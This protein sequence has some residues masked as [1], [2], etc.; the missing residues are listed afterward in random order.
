MTDVDDTPAPSTRRGLTRRTTVLAGLVSAAVLIGST[1]MVW[2]EASGADLAG[3]EQ[4]IDVLGADAAPAAAAVAMVAI[5]AAVAT[6]LSSRWI[7]L[8]T[9]PVLI[10]SGLIAAS[11]MIGVLLDPAAASSAAVSEATGV[12][13]A[14][15]EASS[16]LW[17][18]LSL[19][20]ALAV[21]AVGVT[22][23]A[24]G[25]RWPTGTRYRRATVTTAADP[26]QDPAA[27]WDALT[28]G[29]DPSLE[30]ESE[31]DRE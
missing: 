3:T 12:V 6:S 9:G 24:V 26:A 30:R 14:Q 23:L 11:S 25:G 27:A 7:R 19:L 20:L 21:T 1:R 13:G 8:V 29:E 15:S 31:R 16:T 10:A 18:L 4:A 22:V 28:R 2:T 17:P 5:A